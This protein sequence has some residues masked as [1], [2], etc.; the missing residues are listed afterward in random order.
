M[1]EPI[2]II[3]RKFGRGLGARRKR[4][5]I[6]GRI[7]SERKH[8]RAQQRVC[9]FRNQSPHRV[10]GEL[11]RPILIEPLFERSALIRPAVVIIAGC[12]HR[13]DSRKMRR[14]GNRGEHL[15]C[16]DVGTADHA[17]FAVRGWQRRSPFDGVVTVVGLVAERIPLT[18][19]CVAPTNILH[20]G[21]V[22]VR[23]NLIR[24]PDRPAHAFIVGRAHQDDRKCP[25]S[26]RTVNVRIECHAVTRFHRDAILRDHGIADPPSA[27]FIPRVCLQFRKP[28]PRIRRLSGRQLLDAS[29][30]RELAIMRRLTTA[31][32]F[33]A[34]SELLFLVFLILLCIPTESDLF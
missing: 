17:D 7:V 33:I 31:V 10:R 21:D 28:E 22:A 3:R 23:G 18:F 34:A 26:P 5:V 12:D 9:V 20:D 29:V 11:R 19:R 1:R 32:L 6:E 15:C 8:G 27:C 24:R 4:E 30:M 25:V 2:K 16:A 14:V 13:A